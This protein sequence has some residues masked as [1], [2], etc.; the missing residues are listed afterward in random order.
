MC[1]GSCW[2]DTVRKQEE[3]VR[4]K[5]RERGSAKMEGGKTRD[6]YRWHLSCTNRLETLRIERQAESFDRF[7]RLWHYVR[8]NLKMCL[9]LSISFCMLLSR[10]ALAFVLGN[11]SSGI[12]KLGNRLGNVIKRLYSLKYRV[13]LFLLIWVK[14]VLFSLFLVTEISEINNIRVICNGKHNIFLVFCWYLE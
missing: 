12:G 2:R 7:F 14:I 4:N 5:R 13:S 3:G 6:K 1:C 9:S 11:F 10:V 8:P